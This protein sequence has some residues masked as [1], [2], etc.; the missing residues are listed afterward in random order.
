MKP[1]RKV[2]YNSLHL[3][4]AYVYTK[5]VM[6][7]LGTKFFSLVP[8]EC[9][10]RLVEDVPEFRTW[11]VFFVSGL[12][13]F[14]LKPF[15]DLARWL[16]CFTDSTCAWWI[17]REN[18]AK[19]IQWVMDRGM[20]ACWPSSLRCNTWPSSFESTYVDVVA[21][22]TT[23]VQPG[24]ESRTGKNSGLINAIGYGWDG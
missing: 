14:K 11:S 13:L 15:Y 23:S 3:E 17:R 24:L 8:L 5:S 21:I 10:R 1:T 18:G 9:V 12:T 19:L 4:P 22:G 20:I 6:K 2:N 16:Y 7:F